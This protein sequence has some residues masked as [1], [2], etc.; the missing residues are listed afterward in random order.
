[1][2]CLR[3]IACVWAASLLLAGCTASSGTS[4]DL[5]REDRV[6][7]P[8]VTRVTAENIHALNFAQELKTLAE[9]SLDEAGVP[10]NSGDA[11]AALVDA[12]RIFERAS[13]ELDRQQPADP[14]TSHLLEFALISD[15]EDSVVPEADRARA[16]AITLQFI[17][18]LEQAGIDEP[19]ARVRSGFRG[20]R[21]LLTSKE[22]LDLCRELGAE[23][24]ESEWLVHVS[25]ADIGKTRAIGRMLLARMTL[26]SQKGE[27]RE[28]TDH[29]ESALAASRALAQQPGIIEF[30]AGSALHKLTLEVAR[31][32]IT[33]SEIPAADLQRLDVAVRRQTESW[34]RLIALAIQ[35]ERIVAMD[36]VRALFGSDGK[37][38]VDKYDR[39]TESATPAWIRDRLRYFETVQGNIDLIDAVTAEWSAYAADVQSGVR[40]SE[41][42]ERVAD[43]AR[44]GSPALIFLP[45]FQKAT[46]FNVVCRTERDG[47]LA[48]IACERYRQKFGRWPRG[49]DDL[50]AVYIDRP[51]LDPMSGKPLVIRSDKEG[52]ALVIYSVGA[53][54]ED[55]GGMSCDHENGPLGGSCAGCDF[56]LVR[57][58][59]R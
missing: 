7:A 27:W 33:G 24:P 18:A 13:D 54:R 25:R 1:M 55:Q 38:D 2:N 34:S 23:A 59:A 50:V 10:R 39:L 44:P 29:T 57:R 58:S 22:H 31:D 19:L 26:A 15:S 3:V 35:G 12:I 30:L 36:A 51:L 20:V 17:D 4:E 41:P 52:E 47:T 5:R 32:V 49:W 40:T 6:K 11:W 46:R 48:L 56:V 37:M 53:D 21:P 45:S 28:F 9:R 42:E 16:R 43:M 8:V 14:P